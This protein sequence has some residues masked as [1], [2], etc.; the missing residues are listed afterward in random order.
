MA[1]STAPAADWIAPGPVRHAA[2]C[3]DSGAGGQRA[4]DQKTD[5]SQTHALTP[6]RSLTFSATMPIRVRPKAGGGREPA[7]VADDGSRQ[8]LTARPAKALGPIGS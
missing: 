7:A 5:V 6:A 3:G 1:G 8:P 4:Q 2:R